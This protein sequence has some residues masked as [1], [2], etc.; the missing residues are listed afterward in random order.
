ML[1]RAPAV[2]STI[3]NVLLQPHAT[4]HSYHDGFNK[5]D[6]L[7]GTEMNCSVRQHVDLLSAQHPLLHG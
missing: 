6:F 4:P 7:L 1:E 2:W 3:F 5:S